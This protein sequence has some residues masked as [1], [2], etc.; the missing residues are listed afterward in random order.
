[1]NSTIGS[2]GPFTKLLFLVFIMIVSFFGIM[3]LGIIL[4]LPIFGA[5]VLSVFSTSDLTNPSSI[6]ILK[7]IQIL[8]HIGFFIVPA[9]VYSIFIE[10]GFKNFFT[11]NRKISIPLLIMG[12]LV[13]VLS[14]PLVNFLGDMNKNISLPESMKSIEQWMQMTELKAE[15]MI[16]VFLADTSFVQLMVNLFMIAV[17]PAIG[18][19]LIFRGILIKLLNKLTSNIHIAAIVSAVIFSAM[20]M[21][22]YGF[23]PRMF[24]GLILAYLFIWSGSLWIPILAHFVNNALAV[25][26]VFLNN[27]GLLIYD[28]ESFGNFTGQNI[29][30]FIFVIIF[31]IAVFMFYFVN[32]KTNPNF[33][34]I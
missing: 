17:I 21:Q 7:Y 22:F 24:L 27:K 29:F 2:Y 5:E 16:K 6:N 28:L 11:F 34:Q 3:L 23:L 9:I 30:M 15:E 1:M 19:E 31:V 8:T 25:L 12:S 4:L 33:N 26:V 14:L 13:L 32:R 18:E 10:S 20:H